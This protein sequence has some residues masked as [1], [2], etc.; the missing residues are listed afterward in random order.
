MK[1]K[2]SFLLSSFLL[3][4]LTLIIVPQVLAAPPQLIPQPTKMTL[5]TGAFTLA[6]DTVLVADNA[7][8]KQEAQ[9]FAASIAPATGFAPRVVDK[10]PARAATIS[11]DLDAQAKTGDEGYR[12]SVTPQKIVITAAKPAGLFYATQTLRQLLPVQIYA[13][14]Q[15]NGVAWQ[16]PAV[17]IE[18]APRFV[19]RGMHLDTGR[20][21]F[22]VADVKKYIDIMATQKFN[23][24]HWHLTEDQGWRLEIKKYPKLTSIGS[25]RAESPQE[26]DWQKGDGVPYGEGLFYTQAQARDVVAYARARH[27]T[28]VPEI[29]MPGHATAAIAAY[30]NLGNSDIPNYNPQVE[31]HWG[32]HPYIFAPKPE[33]F[34]F[35]EDVLREVMDIFPSKYIHIGGDEAPKGQWN[36]SPFAQEVIQKNGL[37]DANELQSY[38]ITRMEKFLNANGRQIIGWDEILEGGLAPNAAVM[39]WRGE[40]GARAAAMQ[41]H[42][43]V[44]ASNGAYYLDYRND[45]T[46]GNPGAVLPLRRV[47]NFDPTASIPEDKRHWLMGVQGQLWTEHIANTEKLWRMAYPR[48]CAIAETAWS[49]NTT[50]DFYDFSQRLE[51]EVERLKIMGITPFPLETVKRPVAMWQSGEI[52]QDWIVQEWEITPQISKAGTVEATFQYTSGTHRLDISKVELL[53]DGQVVATDE[54]TGLT[55]GATKDNVYRLPLAN[56]AR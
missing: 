21:F 5:G 12:L 54:H 55:G 46:P 28:V 34:A 40:V 24:F 8:E 25:K 14:N 56:Y 53:R 15:Q 26:P 38:F 43:V 31:T 41:D 33:T 27:I 44:M 20:N 49:Q 30:P 6:R 19:W 4:S 50:K 10:A 13:A 51:T 17:S 52:G 2:S 18:D 37:K 45:G 22:P 35:L 32:V 39:S 11:F 16:M 3:P 36:N 48:A 23:T 42:P 9:Q 1:M 29:E 7:L 47:Y